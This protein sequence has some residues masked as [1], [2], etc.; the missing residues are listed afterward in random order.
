M[1]I[2]CIVQHTFVR[3]VKYSDEK[4][5]LYEH[6]ITIN[7]TYTLSGVNEIRVHALKVNGHKVTKF[8]SHIG[9]CSILT[10]YDP[11]R[12]KWIILRSLILQRE[13]VSVGNFKK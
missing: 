5:V 9:L 7:N 1:L 4:I 8:N 11:I 6:E 3:L 10:A 2:T 13:N 12:R